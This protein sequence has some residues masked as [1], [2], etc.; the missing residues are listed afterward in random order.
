LIVGALTTGSVTASNRQPS[1]PAVVHDHIRL[2]QHQILAL[3]RIAVRIGARYVKQ[4]GTVGSGE[5]VGCASCD[6][7][8]S[9]G[10]V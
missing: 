7:K 8:L 3:T 6:R 1:E 5:A 4:A 9:T 2:R 10:S